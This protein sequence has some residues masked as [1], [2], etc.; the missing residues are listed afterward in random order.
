MQNNNL[1]YT[2]NTNL[3]N[4]SG[5]DN[6]GGNLQYTGSKGEIDSGYSSDQNQR[7]I[8]YGASGSM[9]LHQHGLTLG[10]ASSG[11]TGLVYADHVTDGKISNHTGIETDSRGYAL[12]PDLQNYRS[13]EIS[14]DPESL[15]EHVDIQHLVLKK[16]PAKDSIVPY[17]FKT[18]VGNKI[19]FVISQNRVPFG[20][21]ATIAGATQIVSNG[22]VVYFPSA[23]DA[24][25][26]AISWQDEKINHCQAAYNIKNS[27]PLQMGI[28]KVTLRCDP[29]H[30]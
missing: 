19:Y 5:D 8:T 7:E 23:P 11:A 26:M 24:G 12:I 9:L 25:V 2:L 22:G 27:S 10:Q 3:E 20:A 1:D 29:S 28:Y 4:Q 14:L 13:N 17:T 30:A 6:W 21:E 16:I 18:T 15:G